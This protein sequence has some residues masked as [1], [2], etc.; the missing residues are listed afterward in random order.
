V[1]DHLISQ[2]GESQVAYI[3]CDYRDQTNQT[4]VHILGSFLKQLLSTAIYAVPEAIISELEAIQRRG[5]RVETSDVTQML[6]SM[7]SQLNFCFLCID[8]LDE[9]EPRVRLE[10][11]KLLQSEFSVTR[12][13]LTGRSH[14]QLEVDRV[15]QVNWEDSIRI[16][17]NLGDIEAYLHHEIEVDMEINPD[18]M[19]ET[20][21]QEILRAILSKANGM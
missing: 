17:A 2:H 6:K 12:I 19:N 3:Y 21:K 13:F 1:I 10:L 8:A 9:L 5:K 20:L 16:T 4:V 14:I 11:L 15:L 7:V 18:E